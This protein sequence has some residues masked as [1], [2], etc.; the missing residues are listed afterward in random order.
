MYNRIGK[1]KRSINRGMKIVLRES[2]LKFVKKTPSLGKKTNIFICLERGK[3]MNLAY[4]IFTVFE[5]TEKM[6]EKSRN[7][8]LAEFFQFDNSCKGMCSE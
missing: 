7:R 4:R 2:F 5:I 6:R 8:I 3:K 1:K